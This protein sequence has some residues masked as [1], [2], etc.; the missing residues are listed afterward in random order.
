MFEAYAKLYA[1]LA[2]DFDG[3]REETGAL[4]KFLDGKS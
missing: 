3:K 1:R 4:A 2:K